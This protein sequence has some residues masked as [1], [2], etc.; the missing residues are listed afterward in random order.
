MALMGCL[1]VIVADDLDWNADGAPRRLGKI[2]TPHQ[3]DGRQ[4]D[5]GVNALK[6]E[7]RMKARI[8]HTLM[9]HLRL[10]GCKMIM[11]QSMS[12][13]RD[14]LNNTAQLLPNQPLLNSILVLICLE[15][16]HLTLTSTW[17]SAR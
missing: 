17:I 2:I 5:E 1:A 6:P 10:V 12:M 11:L 8:A 3:K 15:T 13:D 14:L 9:N 7:G 16:C 4:S